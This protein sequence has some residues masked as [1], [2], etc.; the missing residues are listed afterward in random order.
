MENLK[1]KVG[2]VS[3]GLCILTL[4][5]SCKKK[6]KTSASCSGTISYTTNITPILNQ[7]CTSCHN[8]SNAKG[9]YN[10]TTYSNV[11]SNAGIILNSM[12]HTSGASSMPQGASQ[13]A[14]SIIDQFDCWVQQGKQNN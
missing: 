3:L 4:T 11:K 12:R 7:N 9:G 8:A 13:L 2:L 10:L 6:E 5:F 1:T 14:T